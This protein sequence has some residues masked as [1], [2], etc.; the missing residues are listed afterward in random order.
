MIIEAQYKCRH[1]LRSFIKTYKVNDNFSEKDASSHAML[2]EL[3][4]CYRDNPPPGMFTN[5]I[6]DKSLRGTADLIFTRNKPED[7]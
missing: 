7:R 5:H 6:I 3:H 4:H 1:C 2:H